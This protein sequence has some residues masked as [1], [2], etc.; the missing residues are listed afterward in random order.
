M[1]EQELRFKQDISLDGQWCFVAKNCSRFPQ[2]SDLY[3]EVLEWCAERWGAPD[4]EA[5]LCG[6]LPRRWAWSPY[7][8]IGVRQED[9]MDFKLRWC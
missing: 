6:P 2:P 1:D 7:L 8:V 4:Q 3:V 9:A 5:G